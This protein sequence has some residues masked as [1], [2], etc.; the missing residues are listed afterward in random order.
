MGETVLDTI[1]RPSL[2]STPFK[3]HGVRMT[4]ARERRKSLRRSID[5]FVQEIVDGRPLLHPA[6]NLS[7]DGIYIL[8]QS[9]RHIDAEAEL[10]LEFTLPAGATISTRGRVV[11]VDDR[12][13][14]LGLGIRFVTLSGEAKQLIYD[15]VTARPSSAA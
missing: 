13:G 12:G 14:E 8:A 4:E 7:A 9:G 6:I 1:E 3:Q 2:V 10:D 11:Y 15:F 5:I